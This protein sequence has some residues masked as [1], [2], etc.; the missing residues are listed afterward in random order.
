[1]YQFAKNGTIG[2]LDVLGLRPWP[3]G[4]CLDPNKYDAASM[5]NFECCGGKL[6][7]RTA[8]MMPAGETYSEW[9][10]YN[11][12]VGECCGNKLTKPWDGVWASGEICCK[13]SNSTETVRKKF[14]HEIHFS[15][16]A[17]C[18][19]SELGGSEFLKAQGVTEALKRVFQE[20]GRTLPG[21]AV[22][23]LTIAG[24]VGLTISDAANVA[25][26]I[27]QC[28]KKVCPAKTD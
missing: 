26:A 21:V 24:T 11:K 4:C 2:I 8:K 15:S 23:R 18:A 16:F 10:K 28:T 27:H 3:S 25:D 22:S 12:L 5:A 7:R 17:D 1:M 13:S 20:I 14:Y 6:Y 9:L 19:F